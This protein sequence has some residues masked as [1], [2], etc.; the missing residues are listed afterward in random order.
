VGIQE[1][2]MSWVCV[3]AYLVT[4]GGAGLKRVGEFWEGPIPLPL[5]QVG[6]TLVL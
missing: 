4:D 3:C 6:P 5:G 1:N 2:G